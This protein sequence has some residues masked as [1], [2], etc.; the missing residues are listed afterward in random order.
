MA[1]SVR[2]IAD[3]RTFVGSV[4]DVYDRLMVPMIFTAP[5]ASLAARVAERRPARILETAAGTGALTRALLQ[6]CPDADVLATDVNQP[7]L[8]RAATRVRDGARVRFEQADA[9]DLPVSDASCDVVA[10]QFGVMFFPDRVRGHREALR[11]LRPGG[12]LV[13]NVWDSLATNDFARVVTQAV[14]GLTDAGSLD[15]MARLPHGYHQE[16]RISEDLARAGF[17]TASIDPVEGE[18]VTTAEDA[19]T[20]LCQGTPLLGELEANPAVSVQDATTAARDAL[21]YE[22]GDGEI[23]GHMRWL[24]I[25]AAAD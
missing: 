8:D 4:P 2:G 3:G 19:A 13:F 17:R 23:R 22:F 21:R 10:C 20:A 12:V 15:F 9:L 11:A 16:D 24:E 25:V 18:S 1:D 5:A 7:M 14:Q 6:T